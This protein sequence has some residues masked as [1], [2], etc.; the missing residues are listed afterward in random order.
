MEN[1]SPSKNS[2]GSHQVSKFPIIMQVSQQLFTVSGPSSSQV[3]KESFNFFENGLVKVM[4]VYFN[5]SA[6]YELFPSYYRDTI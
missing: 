5:Q 3:I 2:G 6:E 4:I 1:S